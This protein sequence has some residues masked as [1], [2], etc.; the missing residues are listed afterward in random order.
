[1]GK[2][3]KTSSLWMSDEMWWSINVHSYD[4]GFNIAH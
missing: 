3:A 4:K 2:K 1:M